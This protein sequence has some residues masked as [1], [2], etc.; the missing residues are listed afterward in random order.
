MSNAYEQYGEIIECQNRE[1]AEWLL[2]RLEE[3]NAGGDNTV[4]GKC[5]IVYGGGEEGG[6]FTG[7]A[8]AIAAFQEEFKIKAPWVGS[9]GL[10]CDNPHKKLSYSGAI[11]IQG[12]KEY[13]INA[14]DLARAKARRLG[15]RRKADRPERI[16]KKKV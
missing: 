15:L 3:E 9:Y 7:V 14:T 6:S 1:Q 13:W 2:N 16:R 5:V 11:V 4:E 8:H 10:V 12:G